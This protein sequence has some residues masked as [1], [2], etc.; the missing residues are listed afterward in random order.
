MPDLRDLTDKVDDLVVAS[1]GR[2]AFRIALEHAYATL[3]KGSAD[4][5]V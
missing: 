4:E 3:F 2:P 5:E 1:L